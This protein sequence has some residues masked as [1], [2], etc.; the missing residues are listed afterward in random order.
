MK[1]ETGLTTGL[2][3]AGIYL[4]WGSTYLAI[5]YAVETLPPFLLAGIRFVFSGAVFYAWA[6]WRGFPA[7]TRA[8][9]AA[10]AVTGFLLIVSGH[11]LVVW[12]EKTVPS[13]LAALLIGTTPVMMVMLEWLWKGVRRPAWTTI[14]GV[15]TGFAG[16]V[17]LIRPGGE[18]ADPLGVALILVAAVSWVVGSLNSRGADLPGSTLMKTAA[19][20]LSAGV[21]LSLLSPLLGEWRALDTGMVSARSVWAVAWLTVVGGTGFLCYSWL[22]H[23]TTPAISTTYAYVNPLIAVLLGVTIGGEMLTG[24]MLVATPLVLAGV[25]LIT[26]AGRRAGR[27]AG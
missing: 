7:P 12:G 9:W 22:L 27:R 3:L 24:R 17:V 1:R 23:N 20:M 25:L 6:R 15:A 8:Q 14:A 4:S 11:G 5:R 13:G 21:V 10:S 19:Q 18:A 2:A 16:V 26:M